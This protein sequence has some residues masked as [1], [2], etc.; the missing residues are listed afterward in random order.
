[1]RMGESIQN[2]RKCVQVHN[3]EDAGVCMWD[4]KWDRGGLGCADDHEKSV[5]VR[6][7]GKPLGLPTSVIHEGV[8]ME[9]GWM[10]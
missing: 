9:R 2:V 5:A 1:M 3:S 10:G 8:E 4:G 6:G 7:S